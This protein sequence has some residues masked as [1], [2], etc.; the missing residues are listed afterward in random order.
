MRGVLMS[1]FLSFFVNSSGPEVGL[2]TV[3]LAAVIHLTIPRSQIQSVMGSWPFRDYGSG[4]NP[5]D[6]P[7]GFVVHAACQNGPATFDFEICVPV[8]A[9]VTPVGRLKP[10]AFPVVTMASTSYHGGYEGLGAAWGE[11]KAWVATNGHT[12][13]PDIYECYAVGPEWSPNPADW[14]TELRQPL[15]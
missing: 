2:T 3:Q 14:R 11:F 6:W 10:G 1:K 12:T 13:G 7:C 4:E 9:P 15:V 5:R 8:T